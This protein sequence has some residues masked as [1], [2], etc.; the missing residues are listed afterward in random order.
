M[1]LSVGPCVGFGLGDDTSVSALSERLVLTATAASRPSIASPH[2]TIR[3]LGVA[4]G[5]ASKACQLF[6]VALVS[7][8]QLA[9]AAQGG[10]AHASVSLL[11]PVMSFRLLDWGI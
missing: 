9:L 2:K 3:G 8:G 5:E 6:S 10:P 7:L 1:K 11:G 4:A